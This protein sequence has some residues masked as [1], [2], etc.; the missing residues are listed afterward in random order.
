MPPG[1]A[2]AIYFQ[3]KW[4]GTL[5]KISGGYDFAYRD[6][7]LKDPEAVP[8]SVAM[9][10][11]AEI[12]ESPDLFPFFQGLLPEGWLLGLTS[13]TLKID[14]DDEF[15]LLLHTGKDTV[16]AVTVRPLEEVTLHE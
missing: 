3:D 15:G 14:K 11:R 8:I 6:E 1:S 7:Y 10:L 9:P 13:R 2:A 16:G 12:F 5:R 4:A